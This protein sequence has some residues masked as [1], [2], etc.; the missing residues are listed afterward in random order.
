MMSVITQ[1]PKS[2]AQQLVLE[3]EVDWS[4]LDLRAPNTSGPRLCYITGKRG[5]QNDGSQ[6]SL[7]PRLHRATSKCMV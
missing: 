6:V 5:L 3:L 4:G 1:V 2:P 7:I